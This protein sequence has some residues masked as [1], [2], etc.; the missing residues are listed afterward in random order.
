M[1]EYFGMESLYSIIVSRDEKQPKSFNSSYPFSKLL[2]S[3][4]LLEH[5]YV[6]PNLNTCILKL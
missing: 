6:A 4:E 2:V 3:F 1:G 5:V